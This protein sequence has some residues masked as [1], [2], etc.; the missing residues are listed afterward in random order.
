MGVV[1]NA[2]PRPLYHQE[3]C[4]GRWV[5]TRAGLDKCEKSRTKPGFDPRTVQPVASSYTDWAIPAHICR[6]IG[7]TKSNKVSTQSNYTYC[8]VI[9]FQHNFVRKST[10]RLLTFCLDYTPINF[11]GEVAARSRGSPSWSSS[12]SSVSLEMRDWSHKTSLYISDKPSVRANVYLLN[13]TT[14]Y[15]GITKFIDNSQGGFHPTSTG[16]TSEERR[17]WSWLNFWKSLIR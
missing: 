16:S 10:D 1:V 2:T 14:D 15:D 8:Y 9:Q 13:Q 11:V 4:I 6:C 12:K 7:K 3:N 5:G 17:N